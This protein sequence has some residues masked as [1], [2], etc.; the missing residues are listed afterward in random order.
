MLLVVIASAPVG[1]DRVFERTLD[2]MTQ[3]PL[4][5]GSIDR[6]SLV[7]A[8]DKAGQIDPQAGARRRTAISSG[9]LEVGVLPEQFGSNWG[10]HDFN[11]I[12][13][14]K[15]VCEGAPSALAIVLLHELW[16]SE[17]CG[18][19]P[20]QGGT[21]NDPR[22]VPTPQNP[23]APTAHLPGQAT[24]IAQACE[25]CCDVGAAEHASLCVLIDDT[26]ESMF[27]AAERAIKAGC[28]PANVPDPAMMFPEPC[29]CE[30]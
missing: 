30:C 21:Y 16:H 28:P 7:D 20:S 9:S 5:V 23:C 10:Y 15:G 26:L 6:E 19:G 12:G 25:A 2:P 18:G 22:V 29:A 27:D 24:T 13:V 11:T 14:N 1:G 4:E 3:R 17:A 8:L